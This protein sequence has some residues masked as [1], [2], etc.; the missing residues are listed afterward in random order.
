LSF[1][2][3]FLIDFET[4]SEKEK[5][6]KLYFTKDLF[7]ELCWTIE[8]SLDKEINNKLFNGNSLKEEKQNYKKYKAELVYYN[9]YTKKQKNNNKNSFEYEQKN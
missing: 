2:K 4:L 6:N 7:K 1:A 9:Y 8:E 5:N 3:S